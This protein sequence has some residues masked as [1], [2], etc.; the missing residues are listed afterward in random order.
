MLKVLFALD[1]LAYITKYSQILDYKSQL[2]PRVSQKSMFYL[3]LPLQM[4]LIIIVL[5]RYAF[6]IS[7]KVWYLVIQKL[8]F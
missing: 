1:L 6:A 2:L 4:H 7:F 5:K 8:D 3:F